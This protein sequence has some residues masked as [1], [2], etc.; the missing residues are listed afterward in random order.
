MGSRGYTKVCEVAM[1]KYCFPLNRQSIAL[2]GTGIILNIMCF[3]IA[4]AYSIPF[5]LDAVGVF[6][7]AILMGPIAGAITGLFANA[8]FGVGAIV[9]S[10]PAIASAFIVGWRLYRCERIDAFRV[11]GTGFLAGI[12]TA[13]MALP[14]TMIFNA[15]MTGNLWGDAFADLLS[16]Y[17]DAPAFCCLSGSLLVN[18]PDKVFSL[19]LIMVVITILRHY[20]V[21]MEFG[22]EANTEGTKSEPEI[23]QETKKKKLF[24]RFFALFLAAA[25]CL[26]SAPI[27][28]IFAEEEGS[29]IDFIAEYAQSQFG[30]EDGLNSAEINAIAQSGD[31][32]IWAGAYSG[33]YRYNGTTFEQMNLDEHITNATTLHTD[34]KGRLW[35]GT[36]DSGVAC[37]DPY[38]DK[39]C[40]ITVDDGLCSNSIRDIGEDDA[41]NIY[42]ATSTYLSRIAFRATNQKT[43]SDAI[44]PARDSFGNVNLR[45]VF[46]EAKLKVYDDIEE[47]TYAYSLTSAGEG[48][49]CGITEKGT[50]FMIEDDKLVAMQNCDEDGTIYSSGCATAGN[51][52]AVGT[53]NDKL[54][55]FTY[56]D[57]EFIKTGEIQMPGSGG[58]NTVTYNSDLGGY[59]V[60]CDS[61]Y[62]F[63]DYAGAYQDFAVSSFNSAISDILVDKQG[64]IWFA[65]TKDG[66]S[67]FSYNPF[68][69]IF[70]KSGIEERAVNAILIDGGKLYVGTDTG[71][72]KLDRFTG[73][74]LR[75][76]NTE[77]LDGKRIRHIMKDSKGNIWLSTYSGDGIVRISESGEMKS[78]N[79]DNSGVIGSK[80]RFVHE[81]SDGRMLIASTEGLTY[82]V[83]DKAVLTIDDRDGI[84]VPKILSLAEDSDGTLWIGTDGGGVYRIRDDK[85][86]ARYGKNDGL[87]SEVVMKI[88]KCSDGGRIYVASNGLYYHEPGDDGAIRKLTHFPYTNNYDIYIADDGRAF[89]SSS[90][91]LFV[92]NENEL[93]EDDH[94]YSY[95]LLNRQRGLTTTLTANAWNA[96][97]GNQIYL[98]C[99]DGVR[100]LNMSDYE[101]FDSHYQIVLR[102]IYKDGEEIKSSNGVYNIPAGAGQIRIVPAVLNYTVSD[103]LIHVTLEGVDDEGF[104]TRQSELGEIY[105]PS[106]PYG[107]HNLR[108]Q[109]L[110]DSSDQIKKEMVFAIHKEAK[111]YE[112][113]YY[114]IYLAVNLSLILL[115]F[116]WFVAKMGNMAVINRQYDQI[117][118]AKEE[119]ELANNAKSKFLAQMSHEIRTPINAVLG[120]DEMI[121]RE[122]SDPEI[123]GYAADIYTAGQTLLSLINDILD[124]S[125]IDSGKMEI[126]PVE[127]E[128]STLIRD[129]VN[130]ISQRA[131]AKDLN[132]VVEV[133]PDLPKK[134]FGDDVR[135]RQVVTNILTNAVKYTEAGTVW[136][137]VGGRREGDKLSMH[138]EVEDTGMGIKEE[139]IPKLFEAYRRI[140]EGKNRKIEGT[141]LGITITVQLL[142]LMGSELKV[143]S[144][145]GKGSKFY[146]DVYQGIVDPTAIGA[147]D[148]T[149]SRSSEFTIDD[150]AFTS[151]DANILVVD[152]NAMNRKVFRSL[153][154]R[155]MARVSEAGSGREALEKVENERFDIVF[156]DH[157]MPEMDGI[158]TMQRMREMECMNGIPIYVL[159][160]NAVTGAKEEYL[161]LGFDGY[162]A[163]PVAAGK[164]E[165]ALRESLPDELKHPLTAEERAEMERAAAGGA[166]VDAG[167]EAAMPDLPDVEGLD[168]SYAFLHLPSEEMLR[169]G[170]ESFYDIIELQSDKLQEFY[171]GL[172]GS[173]SDASRMQSFLD[174]YRIQVHGMKSA[175]AT[176][177]IVPLA[178]M[179]KMLEFAAK[180]GKVETIEAM[181]ETFIAEWRSYTEKLRGVFGLGTAEGA[182]TGDTAML[183]AMFEMLIPAMEDLDV[184]TADEI[185]EKMKKYTFGAEIDALV[186]K[187]NGAVKNLDEDETKAVIEQIRGLL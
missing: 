89:I 183:D 6:F 186:G 14:S 30:V 96:A 28:S 94:D 65:S 85:V 64:N 13:V 92:V 49:I 148:A 91:G 159:T 95:A 138:I 150:G 134:L 34:R 169:D 174:E 108:I 112:H 19:G 178:G 144:I 35:I 29:G 173:F 46:G 115:F 132:L 149:A 157:M 20:G 103:P 116:A 109:V 146:F 82:M 1:R 106:I 66:I 71:L 153:L 147:F 54:E 135:V 58:V 67:K 164:L 168:W 56:L 80:F 51:A 113:T 87:L 165:E 52:F 31:G 180:D 166:G 99:T 136:L 172:T 12:A 141:G 170:V 53:S 5:F 48:R 78:F 11:V 83:G 50:L 44:L 131:Q 139:D 128:L 21:R 61:G 177:G 142:K 105:Y 38:S 62:G 75:D 69:D 72:L 97:Y 36:N 41:G 127:Y 59:F 151:P 15:G 57:G 117:K 175:A 187:L 161:A 86:V 118:E 156:M 40:F 8:V 167:S 102:S 154:K 93:V 100:I 124:S 152:D 39:L 123:R 158:E 104:T 129:L 145:Y 77:S 32:Y 121:L 126:V 81:L 143:H 171:E 107:T 24:G 137:R 176:I 63:V 18:I 179:A 114:K 119:A 163:K 45:T 125:K 16:E 160:A 98:C 140:E 90:A 70:R 101:N 4:T 47:V 79:R 9:Y 2:L 42:V 181:H 111:L 120:M 184:D 7:V 17:M 37:Y 68:K 25:L 88:V 33:I 73:R 60:G 55:F 133:D 74:E 23:R 155:S 110:S 10:I 76:E 122:S 22:P 182:E 3:S 84:E 185:M 130:M 27:T 43:P 162:L 26:G